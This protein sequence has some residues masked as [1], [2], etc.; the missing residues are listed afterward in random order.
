M[1]CPFCGKDA[2]SETTVIDTREVSAGVY[3]QRR[4][5]SCDEPFTTVE[6][7]QPAVIM[8]VKKD[9]R[10]EEFQRQKLLTSLSI[11]ARK[12]PLPQGALVAIVDDIQRRVMGTSHGE[13]GS[14][15]LS[16]MV[17][18]RLKALDPIAYIRFAS[19]YHQF[20]SLEQMLEELERIALAPDLP[21]PEQ[22]RMFDDV[23][24]GPTA[25]RSLGAPISL[26]AHRD[27]G[28]PL[29]R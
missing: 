8:V 13:I 27:G 21:A 1:K 4:C 22:A 9:G 12:R 23:P 26:A 11:A 6:Q 7:V 20:V 14:R 29:A 16:E 25:S 2:S 17:I 28:Q 24:A 19:L 10:R 18:T 5:A 3:R 15:V